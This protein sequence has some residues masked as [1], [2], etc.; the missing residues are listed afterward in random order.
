MSHRVSLWVIVQPSEPGTGVLGWVIMVQYESTCMSHKRIVHIKNKGTMKK[1]Q[2]EH[3]KGITK[4]NIPSVWSGHDTRPLTALTKKNHPFPWTPEY[5]TA[6]DTLIEAITNNPTLAQP[7]PTLPFFLQVDASAYTTGA[8]LTQKD[9]R[10][11][12]RAVGFLSKT[13]NEAEWNYNIHDRELLAVFRGLTHWR[14]LLLSSPHEVTVLTNHKNLEYYKEPHHI[15]WHIAWYVPHMQDY[16]FIIK[17]IPRENNKSDSLSH[18]PDYDQGIHDNTNVMVLPPHLFVKTT[19]LS[20]SFLKA[21]TLSSV[22]DRVRAHQLL[23]PNLLKKWA[24]MYPLKQIGELHWYGERLV[25]MEDASL[26]RGVISLYHDSPMAGHLGISNT[27][28]AIAQDF[29]WPSM[30]K[31]ITEYIKGCTTC[32]SKKNQPNKP[33]PPL[34]PIPSDMYSIPFTSI[35]MDFI[36]KLP[37]SDSYDTILTITDTF[38]KV[39]IFIPCNETINAKQTAKL[40]ATYI[41]PHYGLPHHII[42]NRDPQFTSVFSREPAIPSESHRTSAQ[43]TIHKRTANWSEL[44]SAWNSISKFS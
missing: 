12:H 42:S 19:T 43:H 39:S 30:K 40:Y 20:C 36:V 25:V 7:N 32:Q 28:W 6:L 2:R 44:T 38:S 13:F 33:K 22:D 11:K 18:R 21:T 14:H 3:G 10:G 34:F 8:I 24:T 26:K 9:S 5:W 15:N 41:L 35:A 4:E 31:D 29:W 37:V 27:T 17:H 16:N 23:H 1:E